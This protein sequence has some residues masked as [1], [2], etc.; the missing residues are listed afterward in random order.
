MATTSAKIDEHPI[1]LH[2]DKIVCRLDLFPD[3][4]QALRNGDLVT[5]RLFLCAVVRLR[6]TAKSRG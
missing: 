3:L 4:L 2:T 6:W 5:G 1:S